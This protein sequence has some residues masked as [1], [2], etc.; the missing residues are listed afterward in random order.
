MRGLVAPA[1]AA[2]RAALVLL[3][4]PVPCTDLCPRVQYHLLFNG[5]AALARDGRI[6]RTRAGATALARMEAEGP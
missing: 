5:W 1:P 2:I 3:A 4:D 6:T